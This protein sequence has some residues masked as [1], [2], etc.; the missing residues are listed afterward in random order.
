MSLVRNIA[1]IET[2]NTGYTYSGRVI[3][4]VTGEPIPSA[5]IRLVGS[6]GSLDVTRFADSD[7]YFSISTTLQANQLVITAAEFQA[8]AFPASQ[9]QNLFELEPIDGTLPEVVVTDGNK[10]FPWWILIAGFVVYKIVK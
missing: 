6:G 4:S 1:G 8:W 10:S 3:N 7:G 2:T 9:Y 5:T